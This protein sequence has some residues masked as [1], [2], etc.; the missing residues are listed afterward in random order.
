MKSVLL[1]H[2][3]INCKN[4]YNYSLSRVRVRAHSQEF[5]CFYCHKCHR[6]LHKSLNNNTL[7]PYFEQLLT[8]QR[9]TPSK[10]A[11]LDSE[12]QT[13]Y[14]TILLFFLHFC[15]LIP[16]FLP[17]AVT[18]VTA[19]N[20]NRCRMRARYTYARETL[21]ALLLLFS[22]SL[23]ARRSKHTFT[24]NSDTSTSQYNPY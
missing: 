8:F 5:Y 23:G 24:P 7:Q 14:P 20:Q 17:S 10:Y 11:H 3:K 4:I 16:H 21:I 19:K 1:Q 13:F 2:Q 12:K 15:C 22:F 9:Y 18:L 6:L